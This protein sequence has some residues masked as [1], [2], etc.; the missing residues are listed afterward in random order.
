MAY[1]YTFDLTPT[2]DFTLRRENYMILH[3]G[4][5]LLCEELEVWNKRALENRG[6]YA[7]YEREV[8]DLR[9]LLDWGDGE[10]AKANAQ[11]IV[12][13][14]VTVGNL[15]YVKAALIFVIRKREQEH[16]LKAEEGWPGEVLQSLVDGI[17][18]VRAIA[19]AI[20]CEPSE[21]LWEIVPKELVAFRGDPAGRSDWDVFI[22]HA[23]EDKEAF[24]R[25]LA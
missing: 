22:S 1:R 3:E 9:Q 19:R 12:V 6:A 15:R 14:G 17:E 16:A 24:A 23:S 20:H 25:P 21:I 4:L 18:R 13:R 7:P 2:G 8:A 5:R 11:E 10:L